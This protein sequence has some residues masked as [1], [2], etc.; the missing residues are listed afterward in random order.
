MQDEFLD[1]LQTEKPA[2][3]VCKAQDEI[4][5][6]VREKERTGEIVLDPKAFITYV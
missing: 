4:I 5:K 6:L 3:A 1:K 2:S